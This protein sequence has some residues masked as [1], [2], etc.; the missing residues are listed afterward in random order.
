MSL[1]N[2]FED[3][4]LE[5]LFLNTAAPNVGDASGLQPAATAGSVLMSLHDSALG[6]ADTLQTAHELSYTGYARVTGARSGANWTIASGVASNDNV[7]A[8]GEMTAGGPETAVDIGL[9][10]LGSGDSLQIY[11]TLTA[12]LVISNGIDPQLLA[13]DLDISFD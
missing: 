13:G 2:L 3:D 9:N 1:T 10:L 12:P 7:L 8:F 4:L 5:L 6:D 11:G